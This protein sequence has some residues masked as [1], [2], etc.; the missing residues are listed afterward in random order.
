MPPD[1]QP[2]DVIFPDTEMGRLCDA[3]DW[4]A[5][6]LGDPAGWPASLRTI[7]ALVLRQGLPQ[8]VCWGPDLLQIYN[9]GYRVILGDKYPAALG[10]P[11]LE[12][13]SEIVDDIAPL[14]AR[15]LAGETIYFADLPLRI[16]RDGRDLDAFFT[17]SYS[18][19]LDDAGAV[20][21]ALV[22]C[23][24]T[25]DQVAG[26]KAQSERDQ[27]LATIEIERDR[28]ATVFQQSPS[29]FAI[30]RGPDNVFDMVNAAY[31]QIIGHGRNVVGKALFDALPETRGQGFDDYLAVVRETGNPLVFRELPTMLERKAGGALEERF[32]DITYSPLVEADGSRAAVVAHGSDVTE[33]VLTRRAVERLLGNSERTRADLALANERLQE[34]QVELELTNLQLQDNAAELEAQAEDLQATAAQL[35]ERTEDAE[36]ARRT[37][38]AIVEAVTDGFVAFN[39]ELRFTYVNERAS[40]MWGVAPEALLGKTPN[41]V[42]SAMDRSP[43]LALLHTVRRTGRAETL[44]GYSTSLRA[45]IELR[46]YPSSGGGLVVFFADLSEQRRRDA[47]ATFLAEASRV[48]ASSND[49]QTTLTNLATAAVPHL[50]DWCAVDVLQDPDGAAWPPTI[51]RV[52]VVHQDPEKMQLATTLTTEFPQDWAADSG[53]PRVVRT[54]E[55]LFVADVTDEMLAGGAQNDAHLALLLALHIRSVIVVPL[56]ARNRVLGTLTLVMAESE[57]RFTNADLALAVDLGQ[58]AGVALDNARLLRDADEANEAKTGFL[59]TISHELRQPLNAIRGYID[60][61]RFGLRGDITPVMKDDIDRLTRNQEHL[62]TLIED[63]L[64]FTRLDAGKLEVEHVPVSIDSAFTALE[65]MVTPQMAAHGVA[66]TYEHCAP[67][68]AALGDEDRI[69]QVCLNLLTNAMRA[70]EAGGRVSLACAAEADVVTITVTDT[71]VGI[72]AEKLDAIFAPFMQLGR[73]LNAPKEGAGLG[74]AISRGLAEA[75]GGTLTAAS[76]PDVGSTFSFRLPRANPPS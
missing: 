35:E 73:A 44:E 38:L 69:I 2:A 12:T 58:R 23:I 68:V 36:A 56:I 67:D 21:G 53:I 32:I 42:F 63:L 1:A 34:Q 9:D 17:F 24:E 70:T 6:P 66:F 37:T 45:P 7:A 71:G 25:T 30:L 41:D 57:R 43:F 33:Q 47:A 74:L 64:S 31:E 19:V 50:G 40:A 49:Y 75:M 10:R 76:T 61:W 72:P 20:G 54:R 26:R 16:H 22:N 52:A 62:A 3:T 5:T 29:F 13:W 48:L 8:C 55:P 15:V 59:R 4:S 39:H 51:E 60:L 18:P 65:A 14:F 46:V 11:V 27:L 28:L